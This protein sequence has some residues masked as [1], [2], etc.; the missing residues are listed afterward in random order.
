VRQAKELLSSDARITVLETCEMGLCLLDH[1]AGFSDLLLVDAVQTLQAP[2]GHVHEIDSAQLKRRAGGSP[3]FLGVGETLSLGTTLGLPMPRRVS[4]LAVE[5]A[6][7]FTMGTAL[8]P[9]L[10]AALPRIVDRVVQAALA[11]AGTA[12]D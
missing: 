5:V 9:A 6:D 8:T 11:L 7:P 1:I 10:Q 2:P 4:I 12:Q 3:H